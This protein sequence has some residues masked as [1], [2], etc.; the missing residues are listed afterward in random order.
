MGTMSEVTIRLLGP[1]D[2][3]EVKTIFAEGI[4]TGHATFEAE[5]PSTWVGFDSGKVPHMVA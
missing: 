5:P 2:W 1:T 4:A 3:P